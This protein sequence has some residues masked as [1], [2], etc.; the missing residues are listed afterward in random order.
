MPAPSLRTVLAIAVVLAVISGA[1]L[2]I[3]S[4]PGNASLPD[5]PASFKVNGHSFAITF[6]A[7]DQGARESGLM[8]RKITNSTTMLFVF[9]SFGRFTFWMSH[10]NSS[11]DIVWLN[12]TGRVG[13]VVS[14][15]ADVPGCGSALF[16][17]EYSPSSPA[18]WVLEVP[19]GFAET[20][21][22]VVGSTVTFD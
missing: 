13:R 22:V 15:A 7:S 6:I 12:V 11:L 21:G 16:C 10:V 18:N 1:A 9:P 17:P 8:D 4:T 3:A 19:G 14:V 20:Y 2:S 5:P